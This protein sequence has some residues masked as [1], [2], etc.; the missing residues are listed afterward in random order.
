[1]PVFGTCS[2]TSQSPR[3]CLRKISHGFEWYWTGAVQGWA[4]RERW[5]CIV[6]EHATNPVVK[7]LG[8]GSSAASVAAV[9]H[10]V[11]ALRQARPYRGDRAVREGSGARGRTSPSLQA[12][13]RRRHRTSGRGRRG[14][15]AADLRTPH[16]DSRG[17]REEGR[18]SPAER[19]LL[20]AHRRMAHCLRHLHQ[21]AR[22]R[23]LLDRPAEAGSRSQHSCDGACRSGSHR[24]GIRRVG[25][26][27]PS[28]SPTMSSTGCWTG[29]R[30][31][32]SILAS[33]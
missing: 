22:A 23:R 4:R 21:H 13:A 32:S 20:D 11:E 28:S 30:K 17:A 31:E 7:E 18:R 14:Q 19:L 5:D 27:H 29:S 9:R 2:S 15:R 6:R 26:S 25:R 24:R 8:S 16:E 1:M 3:T 12:A 10:I 33:L